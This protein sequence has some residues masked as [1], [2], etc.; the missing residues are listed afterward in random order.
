MRISRR[1]VLAG[2]VLLPWAASSTAR[3][4]R[5]NL[6]D[7]E[8]RSGGRLGFCLLDT[9]TGRVMG[10][11]LDARFAM[12][13]T[14]KLPLAAWAL[15]LSDQGKLQLDEVLPL[16]EQDRV[17]HAPVTGPLIGK[18]G[19]TVEA[20]VEAAQK[21][22]DNVAANVVLRRLGGPAAYTAW[23]R[24]IGD[25]TTR[26]DR[27]ETELNLVPPGDHRDTTTPRAFAR[28]VAKLTTGDVLS[29]PSRQKLVRWTVETGTGL[30]RLRAGLPDTWIAGDKTGTAF[31]DGMAPKVNDVAIAWPPGVAPIV[32]SCFFEGPKAGQETSSE[33]EKIHAEAAKIA[34]E[35]FQYGTNRRI[36]RF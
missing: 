28:T 4:P 33:M 8:R 36:K 13:S 15:H 11:R 35:S 32:L 23:L 3:L 10:H 25:A 29:P 21:T 14:F 24:S 2:G 1:H 31:A 6:A 7:L 16:T 9:G 12:C 19:M 27:Y 34:F 5:D 26:L 22:S 17:S 30:N 20:L 18:G